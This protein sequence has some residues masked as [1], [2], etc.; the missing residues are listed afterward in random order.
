MTISVLVNMSTL[1]VGG[2]VQIGVSFFEFASNFKSGDIDFYFLL[3]KSIFENLSEKKLKNTNYRVFNNSPAKIIKGW[4]S[5]REILEIEKNL[6]PDLVYSIG[7]PSYIKFNKIEIG[8]YTNPW[9]IY[10]TRAAW[11]LLPLHE[12]LFVWLKTKYRIQ[13]ARNISYYETQTI[14]AKVAICEL[15]R[16]SERQIKVIPN[17]YNPIFKENISISQQKKT[18]KQKVIFCLS[19]AYRHKNLEIIPSVAKH[20]SSIDPDLPVKFILTLPQDSKLWN[21]INAKAQKFEVEEKIKNI[22]PLKLQDCV[23]QYKDADAVFLPTM[24]EVF[25]A[26]Y[27]EAMAMLKPIITSDLEFAHASCGDA[28]IYFDPKS[29]LAAAESIHTVIKDSTISDRIVKN[30]REQL[31]L[32]PDFFHK[33]KLIINW[34]REIADKEGIR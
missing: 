34:L 2:G 19:A 13:W 22:G 12:R 17:S 6:N 26:T 28:A 32:F 11:K 18:S 23:T 9:E 30:G 24:L 21:E 27:L 25:S 29:S 8:R 14:P 33:H 7:F 16:L 3:S 10:P 15:F 4:R 31:K 20:L 5:R 1:V